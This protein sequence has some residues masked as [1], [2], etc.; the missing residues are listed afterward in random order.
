MCVLASIHRECIIVVFLLFD[1]PAIPHTRSNCSLWPM[2]WP[3]LSNFVSTVVGSVFIGF[4]YFQVND[5]LR[6]VR[7]HFGAVVM[8]HAFVAFQAV[9][10]TSESKATQTLSEHQVANHGGICPHWRYSISLQNVITCPWARGLVLSIRDLIVRATP[11]AACPSVKELIGHCLQLEQSF[12]ALETTLEQQDG[13]EL[14]QNRILID[15]WRESFGDIEARS[16]I[17]LRACLHAIVFL[18]YESTFRR[19]GLVIP[20]LGMECIAKTSFREN[21]CL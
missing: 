18:I 4:C 8:V 6:G 13:H 3:R 21:C 20:G 9:G 16:S 7:N 15:F 19:L 1:S 10:A 14:V 11:V 2:A 12:I 17:F 5:E